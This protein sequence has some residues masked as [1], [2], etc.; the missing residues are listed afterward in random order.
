[1]NY[2]QLKTLVEENLSTHNIATSL[3]TSQTNVRYWLKKYNLKTNPIKQKK[4]CNHCQITL[5]NS[6]SIYC[7]VQCHK[8]FEYEQYILDWKAGLKLG[9]VG[10]TKS[11]AITIRKYMLLK[12]NNACQKC[13]WDLVHPIDKNPLV[14]IDH[15]DG[16]A[17]NCKE[18]NLRVL[19]PN[20]HSMTPTFRAR[21]KTS[22]RNR[23]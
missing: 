12:H 1:M 7:S 20:C 11:L 10:K 19:C 18:E 8:D 2:T 5:T 22:A 14:E 23:S 15:I 16:D 3:N 17:S 13:G 9:Y 21:N 4:K 6:Q